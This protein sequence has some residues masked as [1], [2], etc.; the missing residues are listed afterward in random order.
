M[1]STQ[2]SNYGYSPLSFSLH[3]LPMKTAL[4]LKTYEFKGMV[5][6]NEVLT[7]FLMC[8][9]AGL[10]TGLG[11]ISAL[12]FKAENNIFSSLSLGFSAGVMIYV[13]MTEIMS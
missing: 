11:S 9:F 10:S 2:K 7:A 1:L 12:L 6:M 13:S 3:I 4:T 8:L 5:F